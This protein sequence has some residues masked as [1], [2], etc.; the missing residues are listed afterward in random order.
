MRS[1]RQENIASFVMNFF[2]PDDLT[3]P[4]PDVYHY[5][6]HQLVGGNALNSSNV[7]RATMAP[8]TLRTI[9]PDSKLH[10]QQILQ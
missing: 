4:R 7:L 3:M 9:L 2:I 6:V 10:A 5:V 8:S 1:L